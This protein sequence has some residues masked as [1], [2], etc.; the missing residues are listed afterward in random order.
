MGELTTVF[1]LLVHR[2]LFSVSNEVFA[3]DSAIKSQV[4]VLAWVFEYAFIRGIKADF[5]NETLL[6]AWVST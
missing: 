6:V 4:Q 1:E 3:K 2:W 5:E